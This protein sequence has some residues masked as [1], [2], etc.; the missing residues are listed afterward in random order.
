MKLQN[1]FDLISLT[2]KLA[3]KIV[4]Y[5]Q[6]SNRNFLI[7]THFAGV[8]A[9]FSFGNFNALFGKMFYLNRKKIVGIGFF[10]GHW[11]KLKKRLVFS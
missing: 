1:F 9:W 7:L 8:A 2:K 4:E 3:A 6:P 5:L 10:V 11:E